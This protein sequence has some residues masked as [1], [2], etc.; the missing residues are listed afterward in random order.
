MYNG[1]LSHISVIHQSYIRHISVIHQSYTLV[2]YISVIY[3]SY[4]SVIYKSHC[5]TKRK[6][7]YIDMNAKNLKN[8]CHI[9]IGHYGYDSSFGANKRFY[10][11]DAPF[12]TAADYGSQLVQNLYTKLHG[13]DAST[14]FVSLPTRRQH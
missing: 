1:Y 14:T 13:I 8:G 4:F 10:Q 6:F 11:L 3:Q 12:E 9:V 5:Q 7:K 2:I